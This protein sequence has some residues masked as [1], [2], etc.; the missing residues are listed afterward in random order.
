MLKDHAEDRDLRI[1]RL[2]QQD[3]CRA[4]TKIRLAVLDDLHDIDTGS[5]L[6]NVDVQPGSPVIA[7]LQRGV[8][9]GE[10]KCVRPF[11]LERDLVLCQQGVAASTARISSG[12]SFR[13]RGTRNWF[14]LYAIFGPALVIETAGCCCRVTGSRL[15]RGLV[16]TSL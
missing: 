7:L 11:E 15:A 9:A 13:G 3:A 1:L 14:N 5:A 8:V 2:F 6:A 16:L 4:D 12:L 10:L